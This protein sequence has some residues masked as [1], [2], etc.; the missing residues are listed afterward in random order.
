MTDDLFS[1]DGVASAASILECLKMLVE[2]TDKL[3]LSRTNLALRKAVRACQA[4]NNRLTP[5]RGRP[6][7]NLVLH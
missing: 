3:H 5:T 1:P 6:R 2:E 7:R 4:E